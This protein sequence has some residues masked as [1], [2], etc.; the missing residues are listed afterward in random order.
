MLS[1]PARRSPQV[2]GAKSL[3]Q[4]VFSCQ[5]FHLTTCPKIIHTNMLQVCMNDGYFHV[6][7][8]PISLYCLA[9]GESHSAVNWLNVRAR[10]RHAEARAA[11]CEADFIQEVRFGSLPATITETH[12]HSLFWPFQALEPLLN[13]LLRFPWALS[14][15]T[16]LIIAKRFWHYFWFIWNCIKTMKGF[17]YCQMEMSAEVLFAYCRVTYQNPASFF[18]S[19]HMHEWNGVQAM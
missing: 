8:A 4:R 5:A 13:C 16:P 9:S 7:S 10:W 2:H 11:E 18:F 3:I 19:F 14:Q 1:W 17:Y 15:V 12:T 6:M